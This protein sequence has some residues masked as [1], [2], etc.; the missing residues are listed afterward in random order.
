MAVTEAL[1][2]KVPK[3]VDPKEDERVVVSALV[4]ERGSC[5]IRP[6]LVIEGYAG[7]LSSPAFLKLESFVQGTKLQIHVC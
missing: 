7:G 1:L 6:I 3:T 4:I 2:V 5:F